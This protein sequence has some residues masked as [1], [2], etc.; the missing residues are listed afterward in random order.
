MKGKP[1]TDE[2]AALDWPATMFHVEHLTVPGLDA[3]R[4]LVWLKNKPPPEPKTTLRHR[5]AR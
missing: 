1:P 5:P 3:E 2:L 4:C